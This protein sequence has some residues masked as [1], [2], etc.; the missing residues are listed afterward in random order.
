LSSSAIGAFLPEVERMVPTTVWPLA[1]ICKQV[2]RPN[3]PLAPVTN[4]LCFI[5]LCFVDETNIS[6]CAVVHEHEWL[7]LEHKS[8]IR[9]NRPIAT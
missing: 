7:G 1:A 2:S 6:K 9:I 8:Q 5:T 4:I 3:A